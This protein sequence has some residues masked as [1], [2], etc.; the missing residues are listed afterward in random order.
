LAAFFLTIYLWGEPI[1]MDQQTIPLYVVAAILISLFYRALFCFANNDTLGVRW[2]GMR[3]LNF[4]GHRPTRQ[5]R[6]QRLAGGCVSL[7]ALGLGVLWAIFDEE[8]L[9]WH[10]HMSKT[11]ATQTSTA[12]ERITY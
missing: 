11:F 10:D 7:I 4:D 5:Q 1:V 3:I 9:T 12:T 6:L 8:G 2:A